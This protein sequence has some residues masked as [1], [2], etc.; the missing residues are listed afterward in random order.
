M[1]KVVFDFTDCKYV[2][3]GATSG[4]GKEVTLELATAGAIVLAVGRNAIAL[5]E[6]QEKFPA[7]IYPAQVDVC[8]SNTLEDAI[9]IFVAEHG[10]LNGA[11]HAAGISEITPIKSYD[12]ETARKIMDIS[13]WAGMRLLSLV[14]RVK[15]GESGTSTV[16][17]SSV[18]AYSHERGMFAYAAT[19]AAIDS[20]ICSA[21]KEI[22]QKKHRVNSVVPGWVKTPMLEQAGKL[23]DTEAF[24]EQHPLGAGTAQDV[25][26]MILFL[27]SD[28][29]AW[30]TGSNIVVD[31]GYLA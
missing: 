25:C 9:K 24:F 7:N 6:L 14:T 16:F 18:C 8:D 12:E 2:V 31:G 13:F 11:V 10:K 3:T 30:I 15:Y 5:K 17:F 23:A 22:C 19:K 29:A 20:G 1:N 26:G 4:M 27:L 21:A 28:R